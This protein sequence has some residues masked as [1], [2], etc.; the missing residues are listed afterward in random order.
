MSN[1]TT[2]ATLDQFNFIQYDGILLIRKKAIDIANAFASSCLASSLT[3][4]SLNIRCSCAVKRLAS[5]GRRAVLAD[6]DRG[7]RLLGG[8]AFTTP[9]LTSIL[10]LA[11]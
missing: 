11:F 2:F 9:L 8:D 6:C 10:L 1:P 3:L 7:L 5:A 4:R